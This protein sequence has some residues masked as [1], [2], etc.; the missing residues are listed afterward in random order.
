MTAV[1]EDGWRRQIGPCALEAWGAKWVTVRCPNAL[2][3]LVRGAGGLWDPGRRLWLVERRRAGP[4]MRRLEKAT[5]PLF[6]QADLDL[7]R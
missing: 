5:D 1:I 4:L 6:R 2:A 7:D 3:P